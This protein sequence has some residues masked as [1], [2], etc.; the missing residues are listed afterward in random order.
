MWDYTNY[1]LNSLE[2]IFQNYEELECMGQE[3]DEDMMRELR[4]EIKK[5]KQD[6]YKYLITLNAVNNDTYAEEEKTIL[7]YEWPDS[8]AEEL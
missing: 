8:Y 4:S 3:Q 6:G 7:L 5:R 2:K 1:D